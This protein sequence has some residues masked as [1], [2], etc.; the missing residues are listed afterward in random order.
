VRADLD[1]ILEVWERNKN[2]IKM[3]ESPY[4]GVARVFLDRSLEL[5]RV[6]SL[7]QNEIDLCR[8][9]NEDLKTF[10]EEKQRR[11]MLVG[12]SL[13][14]ARL[15]VLAG[16]AELALGRRQR[17]RAEL[18]TAAAT[19]DAA[20]ADT[21]DIPI[22]GPEL[23]RADAELLE[24]RAGLTAAE[25]HA[26]DAAAM[27]L[28]AATLSPK[29]TELTEKAR[30]FWQQAGGTADGWAVLTATRA[31][32]KAPGPI[33]VAEPSG[34]E[35]GTTVL[36]PFDLQ[37]L[38]GKHWT[39]DDLKGRVALV[40]VWATWCGPCREELPEVQKLHERLAGRRDVALL[41]L[42]VDMDVGLVAPFL[43][44]KRYSFPVLLASAYVK[45][46]WKDSISIPKTWILDRAGAVRYEQMGFN[47]KA[48][49]T[50]ADDALRLIDELS[51]EKAP[52]TGVE[53][54]RRQ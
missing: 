1:R 18:D 6:P 38:D 3:A 8:K 44:E 12:N 5:E 21:G 20:R 54:P 25:G 45:D 36:K 23:Q 32:S 2:R 46:L 14:L 53:A 16:R 30:A 48:R 13:H 24:Q 51:G 22:L 47:A 7:V 35:K 33:V 34:W 37:A 15:Q 17:A 19:L 42:D 31:A 52:A 29:N 49:D 50:W 43:A 4:V 9:A 27:L 39:L 40:N 10:P 26:A 11:R 41:T 28:K